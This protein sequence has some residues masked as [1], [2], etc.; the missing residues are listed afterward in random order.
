MHL[1]GESLANYQIDCGYEGYDA[2]GITV[3]EPLIFDFPIV[4]IFA[5]E[6]TS[7]E[8]FWEPETGVDLGDFLF[9]LERPFKN[10]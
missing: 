6:G 10:E 9:A 4:N 2:W 3:K 5:P 8:D 7:S 1:L